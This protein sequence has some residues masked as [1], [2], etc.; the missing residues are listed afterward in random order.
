MI[1]MR[2]VVITPTNRQL[3]YRFLTPSVDASGALCPPGKWSD[4]KVVE[5]IDG[6]EAAWE[7]VRASEGIANAP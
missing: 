3:E 4:W 7:D 2:W 5:P 1:E 6:D